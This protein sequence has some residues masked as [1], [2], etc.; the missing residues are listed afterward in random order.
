M[1]SETKTSFISPDLA[2]SA[3]KRKLFNKMGYKPYTRNKDG[4]MPESARQIDSS[5]IANAEKSPDVALFLRSSNKADSSFYEKRVSSI[6]N[7]R[8][9]TQER[10]KEPFQ[11]INATR[12]AKNL[13]SE[14]K[15]AYEI[16]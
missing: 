5:L 11:S 9:K 16:P 15:Q 14:K 1:H 12:R 3:D 7:V 6:L 2:F 10:Q 13:R 8:N 4:S